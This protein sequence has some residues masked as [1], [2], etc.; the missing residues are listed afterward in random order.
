MASFVICLPYMQDVELP[1]DNRV[2]FG[3]DI[4]C[5]MVSPTKIIT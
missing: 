3:H 2:S 4:A 5:G 1:W